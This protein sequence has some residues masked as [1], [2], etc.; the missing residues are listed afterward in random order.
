VVEVSTMS[1]PRRGGATAGLDS[2]FSLA[3]S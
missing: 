2:A 1:L 3:G